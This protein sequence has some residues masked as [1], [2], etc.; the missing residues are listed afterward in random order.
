LLGIS[1]VLLIRIEA[2]IRYAL[3]H[4]SKVV[5]YVQPYSIHNFLGVRQFSSKEIT[6]RTLW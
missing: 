2:K 1:S 3:N 6:A 4:R 5:H